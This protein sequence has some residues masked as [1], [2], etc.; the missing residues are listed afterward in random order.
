MWNK[1]DLYYWRNNTATQ[2]IYYTCSSLGQKCLCTP[3]PL[4]IGASFHARLISLNKLIVTPYS[5]TIVVVFHPTCYFCAVCSLFF[6]YIPLP[7]IQSW[8]TVDKWTLRVLVLYKY[9]LLTLIQI[10]NES[11]I[12]LCTEGRNLH[13]T[14]TTALNFLEGQFLLF[15]FLLSF[16]FIHS[17]SIYVKCMNQLFYL[18]HV[19]TFSKLV[20]FR[21][22]WVPDVL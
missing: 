16:D 2:I 9:I 21:N 1:G 14:C 19:L 15:C 8:K 6:L 20:S 3:D 11:Y 18:Q 4:N 12:Y 10:V 17:S 13:H 22:L 7:N 5:G